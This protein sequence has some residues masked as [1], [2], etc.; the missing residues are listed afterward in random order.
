MGDT[1]STLITPLEADEWQL[2]RTLRLHALEESPDAFSPTL[3][4]TLATD[5]D[6]WKRIARRFAEGPGALFI[7][8][9]DLGLMSA[10]PDDDGTGHIGAMWVSPEARNQRLG[11]ALIDRGLEHL[12]SIGCDV[13]ELS[14][15]ET[16]T[17]AQRLYLSRGFAFT[18]H[19]EPL[20]DGS[21]L[22]NRF[23]RRDAR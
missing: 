22:R 8:R 16:N 13:I 1:F 3:E 23:M 2:F 10:V 12:A 15:T 11:A 4:A 20:R 7:A 18:G 6:V 5:D 21:P 17:R 9:P 14:V 19:D